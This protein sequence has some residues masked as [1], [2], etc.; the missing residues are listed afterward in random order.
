VATTLTPVQV[1]GAL[2]VRGTLICGARGAWVPLHGVSLFWSQWGGR[3]FNG[4]ALRWLRDDWR[5]SLV[6]APLGIHEEGFLANAAREEARV[7]DVIEAAI[8][9]GVYVIVDWH[10]HEQLTAQAVAFFARIAR[11][12]G[13]YANLIYETW[14]EPEPAY[15]WSNAIRPHHE[16]V[17]AAIREQGAEGLVLV[18]TEN[19]SQGV[20]IAASD[21]LVD[22]NLAYVLHFYAGSH[23]SKLRARAER[24]LALGAPLFISEWGCSHADGDGGIARANTERW[25]RFIDRHGLPSLNWA[26]MD[27]A[28]TSS[29]LRPGAASSGGWDMRDLTASGC[30]VRKALRRASLDG[31]LTVPSPIDGLDRML[32]SLLSPGRRLEPKPF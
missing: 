29:A 25:L 23:G 16:H 19:W 9:L 28:E 10:A 11:D 13:A 18:G 30:L 6:R 20:D 31:R 7:R 27:K 26:L 2:R 4:E 15:S 8:A 24:A 5:I 22:Q 12:Y 21:P 17:L 14:N 1:H 32:I 3:F